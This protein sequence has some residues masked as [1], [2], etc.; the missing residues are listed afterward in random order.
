VFCRGSCEGLGDSCQ[1]TAGMT[2][3]ESAEMTEIE[4]MEKLPCVYIL[5]SKKDGVLYIGVTSNLVQ[6]IWQH[7]NKQVDGFSKKYNVDK[8]VYF[9]LCD[10]MLGAITREKQLKKWKRDWK[11]RLIEKENPKWNDLWESIQ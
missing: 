11:I 4:N 3:D 8:L 1:E 5:A 9:E 7:K 10:E 2:G 6:R